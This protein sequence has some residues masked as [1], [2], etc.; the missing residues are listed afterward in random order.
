MTSPVKLLVYSV[1]AKMRMSERGVDEE[2]IRDAVRLPDITWPSGERP[3]GLEI[4]HKF[5]DGRTLHVSIQPEAD[6]A[7]HRVVTVYWIADTI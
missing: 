5:A 1:H 6:G 7:R 4:R 3:G 2:D